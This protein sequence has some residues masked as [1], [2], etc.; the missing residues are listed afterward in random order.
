[1]A[2]GRLTLIGAGGVMSGADAWAKITAGAALVQVYTGFVYRGPRLIADVL[3]HLVE[4]L[5]EEELSTIDAAV[6]RDAE[7]NH[8]HSNG[9]SQP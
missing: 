6:G 7:R 8:T 1:M 3:R 9:G 4:K 2:A 5:Q